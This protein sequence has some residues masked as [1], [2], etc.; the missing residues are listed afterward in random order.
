M[1]FKGFRFSTTKVL[2]E[3]LF[4]RGIPLIDYFLKWD[5]TFFEIKPLEKGL[6]MS[7]IRQLSEKKNGQKSYFVKYSTV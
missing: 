2:Y 1:Y 6:K 7:Y 5:K 4:F 3:I